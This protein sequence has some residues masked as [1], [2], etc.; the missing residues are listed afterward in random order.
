MQGLRVVSA[1]QVKS[2]GTIAAVIPKPIRERL[3]IGKGTELL[4]SL[5]EG[6]VVFT[7]LNRIPGIHRSTSPE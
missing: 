7:P 6:S 4:V 5:S 3:G 2:D 1:H